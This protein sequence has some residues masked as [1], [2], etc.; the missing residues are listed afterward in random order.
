MKKI[1]F[2]I[3][4]I[5]CCNA[6]MAQQK[7]EAEQ[8]NIVKINLFALALKNVSI[9]YERAVGK[10]VSVAGLVRLMPKGP[11]PFK[12]SIKNAVDD[13]DTEKQLD[14]TRVGNFAFT[15]EVRY[16]VGRKGAL[17]GFY[18]AGFGT[19]ANYSAE[20]PYQYTD[21]GT[22]KTIPMSGN[23]TTITGG[24]MFGSQWKLGSRVSL[25]LWILG[26]NYGSS[27]GKLSGQIALSPSE[28]SSL[29]KEFDDL[30]LPFT[31]TSYD[32]NANGATLFV[33]GPWAGIR[34]GLCVGFAF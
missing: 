7:D 17:H 30:D 28:Q 27:N 12:N 18:I 9:Q 32:V 19:I 4:L 5:A 34:S 15:P 8:K 31:K 6:V 14:N 25:D 22:T 16:Y 21:A 24:I 3:L 1:T 10:R 29:K 11:I 23:V 2:P 13:P 20:L 26:P 33:K